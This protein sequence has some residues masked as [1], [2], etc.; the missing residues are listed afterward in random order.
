MFSKLTG[1]MKVCSKKNECYGCGRC[2]EVC[3][4]KAIEMQSDNEGFLY[5]I[6]DEKKCVKCNACKEIC[7][8]NHDDFI[9]EIPT[10]YFAKSLDISNVERSSSGGVFAELAIS[11]LNQGGN[12]YGA[13]MI[14][15]R[16]EHIRIDKICDLYKLQGSKYVQSN[17]TNI[18]E[19]I[20]KDIENGSAFLFSGTPCQVAAVRSI[21]KDY[22]SA[23]LVELACFG[24]SSPLVWEKHRLQ[25][26][27]QIGKINNTIFRDK[28]SGW[29]KSSITY[30]GEKEE[31]TCEHN[32]DYF[33]KGFFDALYLRPA[34]HECKFKDNATLG[35]IKLGD[36]WGIENYDSKFKYSSGQSLVIIETDYGKRA[37]ENISNCIE[38]AAIP[39]EFAL[40][41][42]PYIKI[43]K[44]P[45]KK[46]QEFFDNIE[47]KSIDENI[48]ENLRSV[49]DERER[50]YCEYPV[51]NTLL[52]NHL[53]GNKSKAFFEKNGYKRIALYGM[54]ILGMTVLKDFQYSGI[55][56]CCLVDKNYGRF[57][58]YLYGIPVIGPYQLKQYN[59]DCVVVTSVHLYN[60]ILETLLSQGIDLNIIINIG[61]VF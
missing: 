53:N 46:R 58:E 55:D 3:K 1:F 26:E 21:V 9:G 49:F 32:Q 36:C 35:D 43:S 39:Y 14:D 12:V 22:P 30:I 44:M 7:I 28:R 31:I 19:L 25:V 40:A 51:L 47:S 23:L 16:V 27:K 11:M 45:S 2:K 48:R 61:S 42:N 29:R 4:Y 17:L 59:V 50:Y 38:G 56:I 15:G 18:W 20:C 8:N 52:Q 60:S 57:P 33:M 54:G 6:I 10:T 5:P 34:C 24:V 41:Y 13:A 37:F